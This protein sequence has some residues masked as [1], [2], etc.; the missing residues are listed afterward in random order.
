MEELSELNQAFLQVREAEEEMEGYHALAK[1]MEILA[2]K[3]RVRRLG[4]E[5]EAARE[6]AKRQSESKAQLEE[7]IQEKEAGREE[8]LKK[9][10]S[11]GYED[12]KEKLKTLKELIEQYE[13]VRRGFRNCRR[14]KA[15]RRLTA[16]QTRP[17][18]TSRPLRK[19]RSQ[20]RGFTA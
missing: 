4:R 16:P 12:L 6:E 7:R 20:R 8:L 5:A 17:S 15:G 11:T 2:L 19:E 18:G 10:A 3:G 14:L 13:K 9:I 1:E